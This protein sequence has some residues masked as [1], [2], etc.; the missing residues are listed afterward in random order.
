MFT[1]YGKEL[2]AETSKDGEYAEIGFAYDAYMGNF[3]FTHTEVID[4]IECILNWIQNHNGYKLIFQ[5]CDG[6]EGRYWWLTDIE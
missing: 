3:G 2:I 5:D 4:H 1:E 6:Y